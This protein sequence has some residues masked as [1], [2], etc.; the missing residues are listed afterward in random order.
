MEEALLRPINIT[1]V[2]LGQS[3]AVILR[4]CI[5]F[6]V[7]DGAL[8]AIPDY[9]RGRINNVGFG[10][11]I[12]TKSSLTISAQA[13]GINRCG[14]SFGLDPSELEEAA[15]GKPD[16]WVYGYVVYRDFLD[17]TTTKGFCARMHVEDERER[18]VQDGPDAYSQ[19]KRGEP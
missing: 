6:E 1:L 18:F 5:V 11:P 8:P 16:L 12:E 2:N 10:F 13:G 15:T 19:T 17:E 14:E 3:A 7:R 9:S 4:E